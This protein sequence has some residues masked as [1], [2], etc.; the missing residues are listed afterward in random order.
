MR[1]YIMRHGIAMDRTNPKAPTD[2][3]RPLTAEGMQ[4]TRAAALGLKELGVK[5]D[6]LITSPLVRAAQTAEIVAE[7]L[8]YSPEKIRVS[9]TLKPS[10]NP[11]EVMKEIEHLKSREVMCFGHGPHVDGLIA[12]L[13]GARGPFSELKKSGVA[14]FEHEAAHGKWRMVWLLSPKMLRK[15]GH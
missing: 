9:D 11:A 1:V 12:L 15:L 5:P 7:A 13:A 4:K 2:A 3:E 14:C 8:G 6:M 10:V